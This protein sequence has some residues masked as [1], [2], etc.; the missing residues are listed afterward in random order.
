MIEKTNILSF[1][2]R[3]LDFEFPLTGREV[4]R[5]TMIA[6][7]KTE[8]WLIHWVTTR[9]GIIVREKKVRPSDKL[10]KR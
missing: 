4:T 5:M 8:G 1:S 6:P 3:H 2:Q 7:T 10:K 9:D